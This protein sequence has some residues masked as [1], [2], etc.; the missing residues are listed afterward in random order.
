MG[1]YYVFYK[2]V[3]DFFER[4]YSRVIE[5]EIVYIKSNRYIYNHD[6]QLL[7][8]AE[9]LQEL[10]HFLKNKKFLIQPHFVQQ[11]FQTNTVYLIKD[12][13]GNVLE[14]EDVL[15]RL[16]EFEQKSYKRKKN[17]P[18]RVRYGKYYFCHPKKISN[19]L[20]QTVTPQEI[21][22]T[23]LDYGVRL[24]ACKPKR[25]HLQEKLCHSGCCKKTPANWKRYR[26]HQWK[27]KEY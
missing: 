23:F 6:W 20:R 16:S 22:E 2:K 12:S 10:S 25:K 19:E 21:E 17:R 5:G 4:K 3:I 11:P 9:S 1:K 18:K 8:Y 13:K 14:K 26:K 7:G 15:K 24:K 27:E